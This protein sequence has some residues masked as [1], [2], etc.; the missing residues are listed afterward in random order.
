VHDLNVSV[1][2]ILDKIDKL[3]FCRG[4]TTEDGEAAA[5]GTGEPATA[6]AAVCAAA[7]ADAS[8]TESCGRLNIW[9]EKRQK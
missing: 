3:W 2:V 1:V 9:R 8:A 4:W 6:A 5:R 7:A